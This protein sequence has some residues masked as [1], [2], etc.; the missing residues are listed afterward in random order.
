MT[1]RATD[2]STVTVFTDILDEYDNPVLAKPGYP[3]VALLDSDRSVVAEFS[4]QPSTSIGLWESNIALPLLGVERPTDYKIRWRCIGQDGEKYQLYDTITV[5]PKSERRDS[6][7]VVMESDTIAEFT[8]PFRY[9]PSVLAEYTIYQNNTVAQATTALNS[10]PVVIDAGIDR[11]LVQVPTAPLIPALSSNLLTVRTTIRNRPKTYQYKYWCITPQIAISMTHVEDFL[12][13]SRIE[14]VIPE[15]AYTDGDLIGYLERG[16]NMFNSL[17]VTTSFTGTNMQGPL[18]DNWLICAT[19]WALSAQLLAEGSLAFDFSGQAIS[20]NVDRTPQLEAALGRIEAR[21]QDTVVPFKKLLG[22]QGI[23]GGDGSAG[24][25]SLRNPS[26]MGTL[27]LINAPTTR[28]NGWS[29]FIGL[30]SRQ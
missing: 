30:R 17:A 18:M 19:Y 6:E 20:L 23:L 14:N 1:L 12:N 5:D 27:S 2:G 8:L 16:L 29:N 3:K 26:N 10:A 9:D 4:A 21:I 24:K 15:L 22:Q 13:K 25:G 7:I 28:V 11:T